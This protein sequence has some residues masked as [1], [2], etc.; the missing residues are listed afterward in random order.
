MT[1]R[2][3]GLTPEE[4][5]E[6]A[7]RLWEDGI[8]KARAEGR[9]P[10]RISWVKRE[11][12]PHFEHR[13]WVFQLWDGAPIEVRDTQDD[14][15]RVG[16]VRG[17]RTATDGRPVMLV[18]LGQRGTWAFRRADGEEWPSA[19]AAHGVP[20]DDVDLTLQGWQVEPECREAPDVSEP[21][22][23]TVLARTGLLGE[24]ST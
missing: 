3:D 2:W 13:G 15:P 24:E 14:T 10:P 22:P 8:A 19:R 9:V 7:R 23:T 12:H 1:S 20:V 4:I 6:D 21:A 18:D 17:L 16:R 5:A 11:D